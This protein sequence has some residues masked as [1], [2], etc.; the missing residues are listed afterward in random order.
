MRLEPSPFQPCWDDSK[1]SYADLCIIY[2]VIIGKVD[3]PCSLV[4]ANL[5]EFHPYLITD[6][7]VVASKAKLLGWSIIID[8]TNNAD[9]ILISR[10]YKMHPHVLFPL[11]RSTLY[12]DGN[13]EVNDL[14]SYSM[15]SNLRDT[16][17][18]SKHPYRVSSLDEVLAFAKAGTVPIS[19]FVKSLFLAITFESSI[20]R[21]DI[22]LCEMNVIYCSRPSYSCQSILYLWWLLFNISG[23]I[24]DQH[25]FPIA[26]FLSGRRENVCV[27]PVSN[28]RIIGRSG[29]YLNIIN[30]HRG[31]FSNLYRKLTVIPF[32]VFVKLLRALK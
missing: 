12:V 16:I 14:G 30:R 4:N 15:R 3:Q 31:R 23:S 6:S 8:M 5:R 25:V 27:D 17:V 32:V 9:T 20:K 19:T 10:Y 2:T 13:I 26:V 18:L 7:N 28:M 11:S 21:E 22:Q 29:L 1:T 24:R